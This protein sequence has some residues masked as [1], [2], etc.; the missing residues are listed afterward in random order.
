VSFPGLGT[1]GDSAGL[2]RVHRSFPARSTAAGSCSGATTHAGAGDEH[3]LILS[4]EQPKPVKHRLCGRSQPVLRFAVMTSQRAFRLMAA[5][6]IACSTISAAAQTPSDLDAWAR[7][8]HQHILAIDTHTDVLLP[9]S[10]ENLYAPGHTSHTDFDKL[11]RGGIGCVAM[12]IAVGNG[13]RTAE[14]VAAARAE[15]DAKL[16]AI[17]AFLK[18]HA[19]QASLAV[20]AADIVR[21]HKAGRA[22]TVAEPDCPSLSTLRVGSVS[23]AVI[24][25]LRTTLPWRSCHR[26][27]GSPRDSRS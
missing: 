12:A 23:G 17:R 1:T 21:L 6:T 7:A 22:Q 27:C 25:L 8:I 14:G 19:D 9:G 26:T 18:D 20:S 24:C 15:A 5:C 11:K 2:L 13:P 3:G 16:M 10:P 4:H